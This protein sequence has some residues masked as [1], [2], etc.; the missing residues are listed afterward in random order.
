MKTNIDVPVQIFVALGIERQIVRHHCG[1]ETGHTLSLLFISFFKLANGRGVDWNH[2]MNKKKC[3]FTAR[4]TELFA[5][6]IDRPCCTINDDLEK[7]MSPNLFPE[8]LNDISI[9]APTAFLDETTKHELH[10]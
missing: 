9:V 3:K 1:Q 4:M 7:C 5:M 10:F 8:C 2:P 6:T